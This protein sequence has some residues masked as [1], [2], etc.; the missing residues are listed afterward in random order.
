MIPEHVTTFLNEFAPLIA[1]CCKGTRI[2]PSV[3]IAQAA[4][5][6][7]WNANA[8]TLFGIKGVGP[9]GFVATPTQE[10]I[11]GKKITVTDQFR[12]YHTREEAVKDYINLL[13]TKPRYARVL[14]APDPQKQ[15]LAIYQAG[16]AT[17]SNYVRNVMDIIRQFGLEKFDAQNERP[18]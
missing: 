4:L 18:A 12:A 11:D 3:A 2:F 6:S 10:E 7:G 9:A 15:I 16:Y 1:E 14:R 13:T 5:E 17:D 8:K